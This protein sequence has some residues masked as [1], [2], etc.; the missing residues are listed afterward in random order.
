[1]PRKK[2][3]G[4][5][6]ATR[7]SGRRHRR[8]G[9]G[10]RLGKAV[11][12]P[13]EDRSQSDAA[14]DGLED[15]LLA[16]SVPTVVGVG[17]SAG[18]LEAFSQLLE[19]LPATADVAIVFVQHLSPQHQ[20]ALPSLLASRTQLPI[21]QVTEGLKIEPQHVYVI[22]PN[23]QMGIADGVLHLLPRPYDRSQFTPIDFFF[24]SLARW[25]QNR[26]IGV[27]LSGTASDGTAGIREIKA[28]GGITMAQTPDTA[29]YDGMPR[30]AIATG[31]IDL[32]L[33]PAEMA[34]QIAH[35]PTHPYHGRPAV[36]PG[37]QENIAPTE[38][39]LGEIFKLLRRISGTDF[40]QY[41]TP[42]VRRR[43]LR[44]MA[45]HRLTDI[46]A[47]ILHL[48]EDAKELAALYQDLLIHVTRFF[49]DPDSFAVLASEVFPEIVD[50]R[51]E[52]E[53]IRIW[54]PGCATGEETY[55]VAIALMEVLGDRASGRRLQIF[56]T[57]VSES[58]IEHARTG[59][60]AAS[61]SADVSPERLRRFFSKA[62]GGYIVNK[63]LRDVCVFARHDL[64]RDPPF[65]RL[66][67]IVC[68]NVMIYLDAA[69]Q[70]RLM[71]I[72]HF[73]LRARG[74][75]MLGAAETTGYQNLFSDV[76][77][78]WRIY[79]KA[80]VDSS[81]PINFAVERFPQLHGTPPMGARHVFR[82]EGRSLQE[83]ASRQ[84]LRYSPPSVVVDERLQIVQ[85]RGQTGPFLEPASGD[86]NLNLLKMAREGLLFPLRSAVQMARRKQRTVRKESVLVRRNGQWHSL[87]LEVI[88]LVSSRSGHLLIVFEEVLKE[89]PQ[90]KARA[91]TKEPRSQAALGRRETN[92]RLAGLTRELAASREYLQSII[93]ELEAAN[94]ELQS[95]NEEILSS[96]EELQSTNEELDTAKEELQ[97]SNE[98]LNTVNEELHSRN[99]EL[100]RV[101]SDLIN[102]LATVDVTI[103]IVGND[104]RIRRFTP[105]AERVLNLIPGDVGR[106]V[107][108]INTNL[109]AENL[110]SLTRETIDTMTPKEVEVQDSQG[111]WYSLRIRPYKNV[112]NRIDG[113]V[114]TLMDIGAVKRFQEQFERS[115]T[116]LLET[117]KLMQEPVLVLNE[118]LQVTAANRAFRQ[119]FGLGKQDAVGMPVFEL[120]NK[121]WN[122]PRLRTFLQQLLSA[123]NGV[124][125]VPI[126]HQAGSQEARR[127]TVSGRRISLGDARYWA[128]LTFGVAHAE[129]R[130]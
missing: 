74:F 76:D 18:G 115:Q 8:K 51:S 46:D 128:V 15:T 25:A 106:P 29:K 48:R 80:A 23:V 6:M 91:Q 118:E 112:D 62:D 95:A 96:N 67:L 50:G 2:T 54:V 101:N 58:A 83:E 71:S 47:Y 127:L 5:R 64:T 17:A 27:I 75:L 87:N 89:S 37:E 97:S 42:T 100:S 119:T 103:L 68:R 73:A 63:A 30:S 122:I 121:Q 109:V 21:V 86:P 113:A 77:K 49:R 111:K 36:I 45:L 124:D 114:L 35:I 12:S 70:T 126:D 52:E 60:Y 4:T 93:Q 99:E 24:Q 82:G 10:N 84:L 78:R 20:S 13:F 43:L 66:D 38:D 1:M 19:A 3:A 107:G 129:T 90:A 79:R 117:V 59:A 98:E 92:E 61:I 57:D 105:T 85:F 26:A 28:A 44:R 31:M 88:P 14:L 123:E 130:S 69:L 41:K 65:S 16:S 108:Q 116:H 94:E 81:M 53:S 102:L 22:P 32:V 120:A 104:M 9:P 56:A 34:E 39:H 40:R 72:F 125:N 7:A 11:T 55:S 110:E 33:P